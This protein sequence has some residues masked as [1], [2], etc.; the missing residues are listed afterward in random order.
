MLGAPCPHLPATPTALQGCGRVY[1]KLEVCLGENDRDWRLCQAGAPPR[2]FMH[3][4]GVLSPTSA[5]VTTL[6]PPLLCSAEVQALKTCY[7][8][9]AAVK[10]E[11]SSSGK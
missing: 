9:A 2:P 1:S 10:Q 4:L 5:A 8:K 3:S 7:Q 6:T 11:G